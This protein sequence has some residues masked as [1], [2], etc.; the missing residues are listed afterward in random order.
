M[1]I[2]RVNLTYLPILL[3]HW[4]DLAFTTGV[5]PPIS[6]W[7]MATAGLQPKLGDKKFNRGRFG[8]DHPL[9]GRGNSFKCFNFGS[10]T[11]LLGCVA[12]TLVALR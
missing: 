12:E 3:F 5:P 4:E 6:L 1:G 10:L 7:R 2:N 8:A 9:E 11:A